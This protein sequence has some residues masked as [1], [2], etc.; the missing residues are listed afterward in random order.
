MLRFERKSGPKGAGLFKLGKHKAMLS[1][2]TM[3]FIYCSKPSSN[4]SGTIK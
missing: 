3:L 4:E 1:L 2:I